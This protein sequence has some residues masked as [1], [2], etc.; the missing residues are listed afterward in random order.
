MSRKAMSI[1]CRPT[2]VELHS[3]WVSRFAISDNTSTTRFNALIRR[4]NPR[5]LQLF[6][7]HLQQTT[8]FFQGKYQTR[9]KY[10]YPTTTSKIPCLRVWFWTK[11]KRSSLLE[12]EEPATINWFLKWMN[13]WMNVLCPV[14]SLELEHTF[15]LSLRRELAALNVS[16]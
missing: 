10:T 4:F 9:I 2:W 3:K 1:L 7:A 14:S 16:F 6:S 12:E 13:E 11:Q 15:C 8:N 5:H